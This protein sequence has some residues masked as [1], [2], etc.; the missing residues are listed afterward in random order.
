[1]CH[2]PTPACGQ[3]FQKNKKRSVFRVWP[4]SLAA[5]INTDRHNDG[6]NEK[7]NRRKGVTHPKRGL[8]LPCQAEIAVNSMRVVSLRKCGRVVFT[9]HSSVS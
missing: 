6:D 4:H 9:Y 2:E 3:P 5:P 8:L 1:M 7:K